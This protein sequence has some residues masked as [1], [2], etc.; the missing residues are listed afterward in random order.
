MAGRPSKIIPP[1]SHPPNLIHE[2]ATQA[3]GLVKKKQ[4]TTTQTPATT[5]QTLA[6]NTQTPATDTSH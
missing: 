2:Q 1:N 4:P 6:T 3:Q 5:T